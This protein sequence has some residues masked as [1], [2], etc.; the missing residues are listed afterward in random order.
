M[1]GDAIEFECADGQLWD[2]TYDYCNWQEQVF[3]EFDGSVTPSPTSDATSAEP[4]PAT[5]AGPNIPA[6]SSGAATSAPAT[7][8]PQPG[9]KLKQKLKI[10]LY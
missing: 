4:S 2:T 1:H 7:P 8:S 3:C 9:G 5:T 10:A 6:T